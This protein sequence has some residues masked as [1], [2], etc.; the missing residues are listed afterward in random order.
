MADEAD[1]A[2]DYAQTELDANI[3]R[4]RTWKFEII[5]SDVCLNCGEETKDGRRWCSVD[6]RIDWERREGK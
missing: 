6:C 1:R 3:S 4:A 5:E 2:N